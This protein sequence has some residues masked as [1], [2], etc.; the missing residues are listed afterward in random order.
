MPPVTV[1]VLD[2]DVFLVIVPL[3]EMTPD[4]VWSSD[5]E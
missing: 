1:R 4:K 5:D 3:P 2:V